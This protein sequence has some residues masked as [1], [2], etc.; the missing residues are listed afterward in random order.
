MAATVN[1]D[2][3]NIELTADSKA[4]SSAIEQLAK[5]LE[6]LKAA[7]SPIANINLKVS[8]SFNN[9][10]KNVN[11][12]SAATD[13]YKNSADKATKST[14][15]LAQR[16]AQKISTTRTLVSVF[17]NLANTFGD[18]FNESNEYIET[19]NLFNVTMRDGAKEARKFAESVSA[20]MG[21][22]AAEWMQYQGTF[23]NLTAG[24]GI[25]EEDANSMSQNLTQ[26]SYDMAS[27]FN[28]KV[29]TA[30]DKLSSAMSGQVKGLRE[31]G[32]DT[33]IASLQEY[34]LAR[35]IDES[36][37]SMTQAEKSLL[38]YN[39]IMDKSIHIQGDMARTIATPANALRI[40]NAQ[41]TQMKRALGNIIS[42]LVVQFIPYVQ[43]MVQI[44]TEAASAIATFFGFSA[45]DFEADVKNVG[46]I[47]GIEDAEEG[48]DGVSGSIKKIKK[49]LMGFDEL[50]IISNP[51]ADS[52]SGSGGASVGGT[53]LNMPL[54][55]YDFLAN[56]D[57]SKLDEIKG[58]LKNALTVAGL[59][60]A[61]IAT[62]K[63]SKS[64][65]NVLDLISGSPGKALGIGAILTITG[66]AIEF[67]GVKDALQNELD[68]MNFTEI[69]AGGL[70]GTGGAGLLGS[71]L[72]KWISSAFADSAVAISLGALGQK[73]GYA[74]T[75]SFGAAIGFGIGGILAGIPMLLVGVVD[76]FKN[77]LSTLNGILT[78]GGAT[79]AGAAIGAFFGPV[80]I[81]VGAGIGAVVG[82][83]SLLVS[84]AMNEFAYIPTVIEVF[85]DKISDTTKNKVQPFIEQMKGLDD[86]LSGIEYTGDII[87]DDTVD[88]VKTQLT[89]ISTSIINELDSDKNE[90]L[91]NL[92]PLKAALGEA[93][94]NDLIADNNRYYEQMQ[95]Q[96]AEKESRIN[97]IMAT[98]RAENRTLTASELAEINKLQA[99][100]Q[101]AGVKHLS[102]TEEEYLLIMNRL[103]DNT[104]AINLEQGSEVIKQAKATKEEA[105]ANAQ[106]QYDGIYLEALRMKDAGVI[107]DEEYEQIIAAAKYT[108]GEAIKA[109]EEQYQ[110][111][112][113]T[114]IEK[115]GDV[116]KYI[117]EETGGI[118]TKWQVFCDNTSTKWSETWNGIKTW[119][120]TNVGS[121]IL[122][123][124]WW[125]KKW[126][127]AISG[128]KN[129]WEN[130]KKW[131]SDNV[132]FPDIKLPHF[133]WTEGGYQATGVVRTV[134]E[135][136]SLPTS[137]PKLNV[138]WYAD[139]GFPSMGSLFFASE[140]GP[141]LVGTIGRKTAVANN[142]QII[143]GIESGVYRAMM[144]ANATRQ[145]GTQTIRIINEIDGDV[146]GEKVIQYHNGKV[147]QTGVSPLMV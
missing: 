144:A 116:A 44:I 31:F 53:G 3:L 113:N 25:V 2:Q 59:I 61:A 55:T 60:G 24:F 133:S 142:D 91:K 47:F 137:I 1:I 114:T 99:E 72:A 147:L 11:K 57:T 102:E 65:S 146:V 96:V 54:E 27:F 145:G 66:F 16:M 19:L 18:W 95:V 124:D 48:L 32:I 73:L 107:T 126:N 45:S 76:I 93:A 70:L 68:G 79:L 37:R 62:W 22:D 35:G 135:A 78:V 110:T 67:T 121:T 123:K 90:A 118:K 41:L 63:I 127:D 105:I 100:M 52:G 4:A 128:L 81:A 13:K 120:D 98:A 94:Y 51:E 43:A 30:F 86:V 101:D 56:L 10:T 33:T 139:G 5:N 87:S 112:Y 42:V 138:S 130:T 40:L 117:D 132:K 21:I 58:K 64:F 7:L 69:V 84:K 131:W 34:A 26:L 8:N 36:V 119:W 23:K 29:E 88:R 136:L 83:I 49:Q 141:E 89:A 82:G 39:Y 103:K 74:T 12:A 108:K 75:A 9:T 134:L 6:T 80:G 20:L 140:A 71:A 14:Q 17:Q 97:E 111:I 104:V 125:S 106:A 115:L 143:S 50:N 77:G 92:E 129:S 28:T 38:R 85:D 46:D 15:S 122:S 109:A